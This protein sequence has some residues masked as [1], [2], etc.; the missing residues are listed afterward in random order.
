MCYYKNAG[1]DLSAGIVNGDAKVS[2]L[3]SAIKEAKQKQVKEE[4]KAHQA[5][6]SAANG[7]IAQAN[8]IR[9]KEAAAFASEKA[10]SEATIAATG[11]AITAI[12]SGM[13]GSFL[14]TAEA[15]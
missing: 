12:S 4:L 8:A 15:Q 3:P 11:K 14:Q 9:E 7:A 6:R 2:A 10:E 1:G 5:D 13:S